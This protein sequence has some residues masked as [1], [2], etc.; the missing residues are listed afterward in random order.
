MRLHGGLPE[1]SLSENESR[2]THFGCFRFP[3]KEKIYILL[4]TNVSWLFDRK[5]ER[6]TDRNQCLHNACR[7]ATITVNNM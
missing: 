4:L 3:V 6:N 1:T 2:R 7:Q 5:L